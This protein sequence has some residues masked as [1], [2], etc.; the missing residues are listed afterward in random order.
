MM[1]PRLR[2][3]ST[4]VTT[5]DSNGTSLTVILAIPVRYGRRTSRY[6]RTRNVGGCGYWCQ[7]HFEAYSTPLVEGAHCY[8]PKTPL[9][10]PLLSVLRASALSASQ[11]KA[12][13]LL[14]NQSPLRAL[15]RHVTSG[16]LMKT[17]PKLNKTRRETVVFIRAPRETLTSC[18]YE[19]FTIH[20]TN[21]CT[22]TP[23]QRQTLI[24]FTSVEARELFFD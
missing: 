12:P 7:T 19:H 11:L 8:R 16:S 20:G 10:T 21:I 3:E 2:A 9:Q 22:V 13:N 24:Y 14:L 1:T 15:L 17:S 6:S 18:Y 4:T 23:Q 5:A